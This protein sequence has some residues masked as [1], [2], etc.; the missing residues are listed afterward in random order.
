M[1]SNYITQLY[2]FNFAELLRLRHATLFLIVIDD[3]K[4]V[5][6]FKLSSFLKYV[7]KWI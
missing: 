5:L 1:L 3:T 7:L 2:V 6:F 4:L